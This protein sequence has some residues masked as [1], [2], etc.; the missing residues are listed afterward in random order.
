[1]Y[2]VVMDTDTEI[3]TAQDIA[4]IVNGADNYD[5][6]WNTGLIEDYVDADRQDVTDQA[7][8][9]TICLTDGTDLGYSGGR[10]VVWS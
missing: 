7:A 9:Y 1:M 4:D 3:I 5:E 6:I 8:A 10:W 2:Y